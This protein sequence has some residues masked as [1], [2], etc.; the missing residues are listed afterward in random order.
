MSRTRLAG[1][2]STPATQMVDT[3]LSA[4][5]S[6]SL[7]KITKA[8]FFCN[9]HNRWSKLSLCQSPATSGQVNVGQS[10]QKQVPE[11]THIKLTLYSQ[12]YYFSFFYRV[13]SMKDYEGLSALAVY[14]TPSKWHMLSTEYNRAFYQPWCFLLLAVRR[15][16]NF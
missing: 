12:H 11:T 13:R 5:S 2:K 9:V 14:L 15:G 10:L 6:I 1:V 8:V 16:G 3:N 7:C 4:K